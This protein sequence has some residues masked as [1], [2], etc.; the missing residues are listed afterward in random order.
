MIIP[1]Y[2]AICLLAQH[3]FNFLQSMP[4][5]S[6]LE[7]QVFEEEDDEDLDIIVIPDDEIEEDNPL[8]IR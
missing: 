3:P 7:T 8:E 2:L 6:E 1:I 4:T 5:S